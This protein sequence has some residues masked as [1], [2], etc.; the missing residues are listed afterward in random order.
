MPHITDLTIRQQHIADLNALS[1]KYGSIFLSIIKKD[2]IRT[3]KAIMEAKSANVPVEVDSRKYQYHLYKLYLTLGIDKALEEHNK[4]ARSLKSSNDLIIYDWLTFL[5]GYADRTL[6][7][8]VTK[9]P[10]TTR[11]KIK[12]FIEKGLQDGRGYE[13]IAKKIRLEGDGDFSK[14]RSLLI[15]RTEGNNAVN[16]GAYIAARA[17]GLLMVKTWLHAGHSK[18][19]NRPEHVRLSKLDPVGLDDYYNVNGKQMLFPGDPAGGA[20]ENCNCRCICSFRPKRDA[21]GD[22]MAVNR[23]SYEVTGIQRAERTSLIDQILAEYEDV[24]VARNVTPTPIA[25]PPVRPLVVPKITVHGSNAETNERVRVAVEQEVAIQGIQQ[26]VEIQLGDKALKGFAQAGVSFTNKPN[27]LGR[28]YFEPKV[29]L[30]LKDEQSDL[31]SLRHELRHIAQA[32][33]NRMW[34]KDGYFYWDG[35]KVISVKQYN[36]IIKGMTQKTDKELYEKA[37]EKYRQ[38][39]WESDADLYAGT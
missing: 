35:E 6:G 25:I 29:L 32:E 11:T 23:R 21:Q 4:R 26:D 17:S 15:A 5:K 2:Y 19:E 28:Y 33:K 36:A 20:D 38:L 14:Y 10:E 34:F 37:I 22:V 24:V 30:K 8:R 1:I 18:R 12:E 13:E 16:A 39:P 31:L 9:I 27:E 3:A 7:E